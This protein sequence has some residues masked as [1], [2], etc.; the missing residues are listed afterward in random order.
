M[1]KSPTIKDWFALAEKELRGK[2]VE[3]LTKMTP[4]GIEI[5]P[6][7]SAEDVPVSVHS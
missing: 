3:A 5:K 2:P 4:E 1:P 6:V 7:Y